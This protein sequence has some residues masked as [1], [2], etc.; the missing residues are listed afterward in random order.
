M[1]EKEGSKDD[2]VLIRFAVIYGSTS[3]EDIER[4]YR[5]LQVQLKQKNFKI[6]LKYFPK[7]DVKE[8]LF[9][10]LLAGNID[11]AGELSPF[12]YLRHKDR[13]RPF[14]RT[15]WGGRDFYY[16]VILAK[17]N[18]HIRH[19]RDL[20]GSIMAVSNPSSTS[21]FL[22]P[23]AMIYAQGLDFDLFTSQ[24]RNAGN[25]E[26]LVY[27][28]FYGNYE[29]T[30]KALISDNT[31]DISAAAAPEF[32]V[33]SL[34]RLTPTLKDELTFVVGGR[35]SPIKNGVFVA[36][37]DLPLE[38]VHAL[39]EALIE[40][41]EYP[42]NDLFSDWG[43]FSGWIPWQEGDYDDLEKNLNPPSPTETRIVRYLI[44]FGISVAV[45]GFVFIGW[46]AKKELSN[47]KDHA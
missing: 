38:V 17:K 28:R 2:L 13:M 43:A 39:K 6:D 24:N 7:N 33:K 26:Q 23:R 21:G 10:E 30:F 4:N 46:L 20:E 1:A 27:Y 35:S 9:S 40:L 16:S 41:T 44:F 42:P 11:V 14:A 15:I 8:K 32:F 36:R 3:K 34:F 45:G 5:K 25:A 22:Y 19:I 31:A 47:G 12:D 18:S 29:N 37:N